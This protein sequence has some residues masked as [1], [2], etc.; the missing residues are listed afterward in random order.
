MKDTFCNSFSSKA[1]LNTKKKGEVIEDNETK[2]KAAA[3]SFNFLKVRPY[4][5][6][7]TRAIPG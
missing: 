4:Q 6:N 7:F 3:M 1:T 5:K 2:K